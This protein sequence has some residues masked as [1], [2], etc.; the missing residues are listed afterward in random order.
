MQ[1]ALFSVSIL[2]TSINLPCAPE[3]AISFGQILELRLAN[4]IGDPRVDPEACFDLI[5]M[6]MPQLLLIRRQSLKYPIRHHILH[7]CKNT[8]TWKLIKP[9]YQNN[10]V[11]VWLLYLYR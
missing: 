1:E 2:F 3:F 6:G 4:H 7:T 5:S 11:S 9:F 10:V 8:T